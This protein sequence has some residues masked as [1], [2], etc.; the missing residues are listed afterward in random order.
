MTQNE[1][2]AGGLLD[3]AFDL[4][5]GNP[6]HTAAYVGGLALLGI[7]LDVAGSG[8]N[9]IYSIANAAVAYFLSRSML[10]GAGF[11]LGAANRFGAYFGLGILGG[12]GMLV[13]LVLLVVP[14]IILFV[15]WL[16]AYGILIAED[17]GVIDAMR[18]SWHRT[19]DSFW[20]LFTVSLV[21]WAVLAISIGGM[22]L[23]SVDPGVSLLA[24]SIPFNL[25]LAAAS[26]FSVALGLAAYLLLGPQVS[27][28]LG[29][30]FA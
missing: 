29:E 6:L 21:Y 22:V 13:G 19:A 1:L 12:L 9:F 15:R 14:G 2:S 28:E 18:T 16:P 23:L 25:L 8:S 20:P 11:S 4:L 24:S 7:V 30:V 10:A 5:K 3:R 17:S 27:A 26:A